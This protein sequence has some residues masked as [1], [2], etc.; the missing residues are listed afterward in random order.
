[1]FH[2][3]LKLRRAFTLVE[4]LVV[5]GIIA[6]LIAILLPTISRAREQT[7]FVLCKNN[8]RQIGYALRMYAN[9]N[10]DYYPDAATLGGAFFRV[11]LGQK[12]PGNPDPFSIS[13]TYGMPAVLDQGHYLPGRSAVWVCPSAP[14]WMSGYKNTYTWTLLWGAQDKITLSLPRGRPANADVFYVYDNFAN[15]AYTTGIRRGMS[16]SNPVRPTSQWILPHSYKVKVQNS[17]TNPNARRGAINVL[18]LDG[19]VGAAI[20]VT[21]PLNPSG[22]PSE[23]PIHGE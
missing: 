19:S 17:V 12:I 20:Y 9:D 16:D 6:I 11:G 15:S 10:G 5:I 14:D 21:N 7:K 18:Y 3:T 13:E 1:M 4:L 8:L 23:I 2:V 22:A